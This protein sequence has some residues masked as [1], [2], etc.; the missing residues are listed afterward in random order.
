[1]YAQ[2]VVFRS[3]SQS[4]ATCHFLNGSQFVSQ[5]HISFINSFPKNIQFSQ[6]GA[7]PGILLQISLSPTTLKVI[8]PFSPPFS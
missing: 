3:V 6:Y 5:K 4:C 8:G 2:K 7:F 1:K